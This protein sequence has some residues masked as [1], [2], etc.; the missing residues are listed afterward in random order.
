MVKMSRHMDHEIVNRL[1]KLKQ[2]NNN[3]AEVAE[4]DRLVQLKVD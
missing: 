1:E 3:D 2:D 4:V